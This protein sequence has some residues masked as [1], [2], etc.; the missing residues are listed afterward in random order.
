[1]RR[2]AFYAPLKPPDDPVPSGDRTLARALLAA[3]G[4]SGLGEPE[5]ASRLRSRDGQG[6]AGAQRSIL[7]ASQDEIARLRELEPPALWLTY[8]SYYKAPDLLGPALSGHWGIPYALIEA[9]RARKRL[10]GPHAAF[11]AAAERACDRA[12]VI[13]YMTEHDRQSLEEHRPRGQALARLRPFLDR[14][15]LEPEP[16]RAENG[17]LRLV[18]CAMFR[19]GDKMA[20][21]AALAA[22]MRRVEAA[23]WRLAIIGDGQARREVEALFSPFGSRVEFLGALSQENVAARFRGAD[24]LVW[25]GVGEAWGMVYLEA[26]AEGCPALAENRPGVS[27]VVRDGGWL[28]RPNDPAAFATAVERLGADRQALREAGRRGRAQVAAEHLR[29]SACTT[30]AA[31]LGPLMG[32]RC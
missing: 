12:D 30:L 24:L 5:L 8:H 9:T 1:M 19:P 4:H 11:A 7:A 31:A 16:E 28:V 23:P 22:A 14:E 3:L 6:D 26:Q 10:E 29:G 25:P 18:A 2:I 20:S 21:Y 17:P 27:E 13:F 15:S 32:E